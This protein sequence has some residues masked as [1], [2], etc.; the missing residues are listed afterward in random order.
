MAG[1]KG[2]KSASPRLSPS[3][4]SAICWAAKAES[5]ELRAEKKAPAR[6]VFV[7]GDERVRPFERF[8]VERRGMGFDGFGLELGVRALGLRIAIVAMVAA[9]VR[10]MG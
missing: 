9:I 5:E 2:N 7:R 6:A 10:E 1:I 3:A 8:W 4:I